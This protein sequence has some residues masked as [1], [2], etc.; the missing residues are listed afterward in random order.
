MELVFE[1][2]AL[3]NSVHIPLTHFRRMFNSF[4][5]QEDLIVFGFRAFLRQK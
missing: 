1:W 3:N 4:Q 2:I 5:I